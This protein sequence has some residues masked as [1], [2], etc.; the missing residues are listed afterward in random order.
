MLSAF[1][2]KL[3]AGGTHVYSPDPFVLLCG[4]E[5]SGVDIDKPKSLRD[6]FLKSDFYKSIK[7]AEVRQIEDIREYFDKDSPY[8]ELFTFERHIAQLSDLVLLFSE[9]P[10]SFAELGAFASHADIANKTLVVIQQKY[11]GK[12]SF[13]AKGPIAYLSDVSEK[14]VFSLT[15][16]SIGLR[17]NHFA[18]VKPDKLLSLLAGPVADRLEESKG[19]KTLRKSSFSHRCRLYIAFL[20]EFQV[21]KDAELIQLFAAFGISISKPVLNQIAFCCKCVDWSKTAKSGFDRIHFALDLK[22]EAA[23]FNLEGDFS[24][25]IKRR[26]E[27]RAHWSKTDPDR[28]EARNEAML[29]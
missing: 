6:A 29:P 16:S 26:L 12:D 17:G 2:E 13:I 8:N 18:N 9:S 28:L 24:D 22:K 7:N 3:E 21:L 4:G 11:L 1:I 15:N 5:R 25:R 19:S 27:I 20:R 10:G 23:K 14:S